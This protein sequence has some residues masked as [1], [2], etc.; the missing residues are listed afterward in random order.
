[1]IKYEKLNIVQR[2]TRGD[3]VLI[4]GER[5]TPLLLR[6]FTRVH[7]RRHDS[8]SRERGHRDEVVGDA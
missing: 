4:G 1:M 5:E 7:R 8:L 3:R 2:V 6:S